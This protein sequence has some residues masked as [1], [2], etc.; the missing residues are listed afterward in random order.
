MW[1]WLKTLGR[2]TPV[3]CVVLRIDGRLYVSECMNDYQAVDVAAALRA[4]GYDVYF[5]EKPSEAPKLDYAAI[6]KG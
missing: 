2:A 6:L 3:P 4:K 1:K 5:P